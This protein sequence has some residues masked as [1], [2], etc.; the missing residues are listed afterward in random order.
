MLIMLG[1][2]IFAGV[3][4]AKRNP[5][6]P[7]KIPSHQ[8]KTCLILSCLVLLWMIV[9]TLQSLIAQIANGHEKII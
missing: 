3:F 8:L 7:D 2:L 1:Y 5:V 4:A 6:G 9:Q